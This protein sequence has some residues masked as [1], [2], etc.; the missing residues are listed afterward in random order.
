MGQQLVVHR[1]VGVPARSQPGGRESHAERSGHHDRLVQ[2]DPVLDSVTKPREQCPC[3]CAVGRHD[4]V[5]WPQPPA[6]L[7]AE[8]GRDV[9]VA[10]GDPWL[11]T[12]FQEGVNEVAVE[13]HTF[14]VDVA[15]TI[16]N[17]TAPCD[18]EAIGLEAQLRH[19]CNVSA[20]PVV[21]VV[22]HVAGA[23]GNP[24]KRCMSHLVPDRR[25]PT[26]FVSAALNLVGSR[27]STKGEA[28]WKLQELRLSLL[29]VILVLGI[30]ARPR[31]RRCQLDGRG[32]LGQHPEKQSSDS[33][34][35]RSLRHVRTERGGRAL[36][37]PCL[38]GA[39]DTRGGSNH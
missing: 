26:A 1:C 25:L 35:T 28:L 37:G 3:I 39:F 32:S 11:D 27:G 21:V 19:D 6:E 12:V 31:A 16:G 8:R 2:R 9:P 38:G 14:L 13:A 7:I 36:H 22:G 10:H 24:A 18:G 4:P 33:A 20:E 17:H 15:D 34:P 5:L 29:Q 30:C 23:H